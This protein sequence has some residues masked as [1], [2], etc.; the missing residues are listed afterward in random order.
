MKHIAFILIFTLLLGG[1]TAQEAPVCRVVT[2]AQIQY[3][4]TLS[5]TYT[6][7]ES[8]QSVLNYLR[9]LHPHGPVIPTEES[10]L[11]CTIT[12][13]YSHGPDSIIVLRDFHYFQQDGGY[14][15]VVDSSHA[16]LL[17]PMLLLL[18]SDET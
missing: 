14:W 16:R 3:G 7:D 4:D 2:G 15:K 10:Q 9:L 12:L 17:Y 6:E 11:S 8:L 1:C 5:R 13:Q 18:P